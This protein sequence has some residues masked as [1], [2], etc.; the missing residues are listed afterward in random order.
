MRWLY[1]SALQIQGPRRCYQSVTRE[2]CCL[3]NKAIPGGVASFVL[4]HEP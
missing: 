1:A 2:D 4:F 3:C